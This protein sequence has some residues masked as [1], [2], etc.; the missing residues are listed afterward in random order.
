MKD[1]RWTLSSRGGLVEGW[2]WRGGGGKEGLGELRGI[3]ISR[4]VG[5][6]KSDQAGWEE[7][8]GQRSG[9]KT[10]RL[11]SRSMLYAPCKASPEV[12]AALVQ[13]CLN[14]RSNIR[15]GMVEADVT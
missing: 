11:G 6:G 1:R 5:R 4:S 8:W 2:G 15:P 9:K 10:S 13:R 7:S 14:S 3:R 12:A